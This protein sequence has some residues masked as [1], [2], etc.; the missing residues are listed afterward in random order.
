MVVYVGLW[1]DS[2]GGQGDF[3]KE[4]LLAKESG[5]NDEEIFR[6]A[7]SIIGTDEFKKQH[8]MESGHAIPKRRGRPYSRKRSYLI[9]K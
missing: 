8:I 3:Y 7:D 6:R 1:K 4:W 2:L 9:D 5:R